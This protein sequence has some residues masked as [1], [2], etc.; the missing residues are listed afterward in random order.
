MYCGLSWLFTRFNRLSAVSQLIRA[1]PVAIPDAMA[2]N[3]SSSHQPAIMDASGGDPRH[4]QAGA[5]SDRSR[6]ERGADPEG[7]ATSGH[8]YA[9]TS[10]VPSEALRGVR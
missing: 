7:L 5:V 10:A 1:V 6:S 3:P 9:P 8:A 2:D 4:T